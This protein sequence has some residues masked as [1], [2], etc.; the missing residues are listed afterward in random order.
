MSDFTVRDAAPED[1]SAILSVNDAA[2]G[3]ADEG[4]IV[5]TLHDDDDSLLSLVAVNAAGAIVGHIQFFPIEVEFTDQP[6]RFAGLGPM[7]VTPDLQKTGIGTEL[8]RQGLGRLRSDGVQKVFVLGH[9]SYYPKF[10]FSVDETAGFSAPWGGPYFMA[11]RLNS[12]GPEFGE[13][14]YPAAFAEG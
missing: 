7:S 2:F 8:I 3:Q 6:A 12:G 1:L 10:G 14:S 5:E 13:L 11:I 9:T 4:H